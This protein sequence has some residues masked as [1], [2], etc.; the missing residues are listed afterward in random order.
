METLTATIEPHGA[1]VEAAEDG[2]SIIA[3]RAHRLAA[4]ALSYPDLR[5]A[6]VQAIKAQID[7][8]TYQVPAAQVAESLL[9][10]LRVWEP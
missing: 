2:S 10:Y 1:S 6:R 8:G 5:L 4:V 3:A 9:D 7:A